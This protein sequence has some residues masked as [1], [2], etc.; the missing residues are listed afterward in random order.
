M[1]SHQLVT[2]YNTDVHKHFF[3]YLAAF[4]AFAFYAIWGQIL[5][6]ALL[7]SIDTDTAADRS[8]SSVPAV[9][10][11]PFLFV[12]WIMLMSMAYSMSGRR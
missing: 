7:S 8:G 10:G 9:L 1:V 11:I 3:Y 12:S 4:Y 5:A 6:R 2:T